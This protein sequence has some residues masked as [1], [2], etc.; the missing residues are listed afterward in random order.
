MERAS[1]LLC[2]SD[3]AISEVCAQ[4]GI[5]DAQYF[6]RVFKSYFGATPSVYRENNK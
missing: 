1:E 6:S 5:P 3:A 4:V 2:S